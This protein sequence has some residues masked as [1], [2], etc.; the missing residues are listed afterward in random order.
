MTFE[1]ERDEFDVEPILRLEDVELLLDGLCVCV[2]VGRDVEAVLWVCAVAEMTKQVINAAK[3]IMFFF[4]I[5][6]AS[7]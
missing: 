1:F 7:Y 4:M 5:F 2:V 3:I 6:F